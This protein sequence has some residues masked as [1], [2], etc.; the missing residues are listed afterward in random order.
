MKQIVWDA[1]KNSLLQKERSV[2]FEDILLALAKGDLLDHLVHPNQGK[3]PGQSIMVVKIRD[4]AYLVPYVETEEYIFLKTV[5]PSRKA[6]KKYLKKTG[7]R[8]ETHE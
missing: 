1:E 5:I 3:Y 7:G 6:T 4:Y 2:C 8:H